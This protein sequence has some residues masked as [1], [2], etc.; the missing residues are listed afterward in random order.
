VSRH[1][2]VRNSLD[3]GLGWEVLGTMSNPILFARHSGELLWFN[4]AAS[5]YLDLADRASPINL[6]EIL[7]RDK[8]QHRRLMLGEVRRS[9]K[10]VEF[11]DFHLNWW[12]VQIRVTK[13]PDVFVIW[14]RAID[15]QIKAE[16]GLRQSL[17]RAVTIQE[18]ERRRISRDLHDETGQALTGLIL[19]LRELSRR[20]EDPDL[21]VRIDRASEMATSLMKLTRGILHQLNPPSLK[22]KSLA[23]AISEYCVH[24]SE[25]TGIRIVLEAV[26][27]P[28]PL[29]DDRATTL[30]RLLQ[31]GLTNVA[32]HSQATTAWVSLAAEDNEVTISVEDDGVGFGGDVP[33]G[34]GLRGIRERFAMLDGRVE[35]ES[36][37]GRG[38]R[39]EGSIPEKLARG[40]SDR[41]GAAE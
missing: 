23:A 26:S 16:E 40:R 38:V 3:V 37:S 27:P 1:E 24:F 32:R 14:H 11:V 9:G 12:Q 18:D 25:R 8:A 21:R 13:Q 31:E 5:R 7:P 2:E 15:Q 19:E 41:Q 10:D 34:N 6:F 30:F 17:M 36:G 28:G 39:V 20:V 35:I 22:S 33:E 4:D 29:P